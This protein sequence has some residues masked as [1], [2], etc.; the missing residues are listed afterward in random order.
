IDIDYERVPTSSRA[1]FTAFVGTLAAKLH[2]ANKK[3]SITVYA[4]SSD[5][6]NWDGPGSQD[7]AAIGAAADSVKIMAYDYHWS[8]SGPGAIAPLTWLDQV[9]SYAEQ[10]IGGPKIMIGLPWYGYDWPASGAA[11]SASFA[12]AQQTALNNNA[13]I[14]HDASSGEPFF[15]YAGRTVYFQ[16]A[17]GYATKVDLLKQKH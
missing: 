11:S 9:T 12:S 10:T 14:Q 13:T 5:R 15:S 16:D 4:K 1:N 3:L 6:E 2:A 7:W 17:A 8:T